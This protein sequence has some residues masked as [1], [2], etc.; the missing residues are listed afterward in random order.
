MVPFDFWLVFLLPPGR[1][2]CIQLFCSLDFWTWSLWADKLQWKWG[3]VS[4]FSLK[5]GALEL[6]FCQIFKLFTKIAVKFELLELKIVI[7]SKNFL[8]SKGKCHIF[9]SNEGLVNGLVPQLGVLCT[10]GEAW[11]GGSW[12]PH[13][14]VPLVR[15]VPP[16]LPHPLLIQWNQLHIMLHIGGWGGGKNFDDK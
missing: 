12:G 6:I 9:L 1:G 4:R 15:W 8:L 5:T 2:V 10:A 3:L 7:F 14:P 16:G 11:K 13:I